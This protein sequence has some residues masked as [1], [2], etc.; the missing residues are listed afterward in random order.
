MALQKLREL[1]ETREIRELRET[2]EIREWDWLA[3]ADYMT[4]LLLKRCLPMSHPADFEQARPIVV[5][6]MF[7]RLEA[8]LKLDN[9]P[10]DRA[11]WV[12]GW[13]LSEG[14]IPVAVNMNIVTNE[15]FGFI[16]E[17]K[18][19]EWPI[20]SVKI[21]RY[22]WASMLFGLNSYCQH[23]VRTICSKLIETLPGNHII[24]TKCNWTM[25][26]TEMYND[27][28]C[29]YC[30]SIESYPNSTLKLLQCVPLI[31]LNE[32]DESKLVKKLKKIKIH[33]S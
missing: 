30:E 10:K 16:H 32:T 7:E 11:F 3:M 13:I 1:R 12:N 28:I 20:V 2:R 18:W 25:P 31:T 27:C 8:H 19:T 4:P 33:N 5:C 26:E 9:I 6:R 23:K 14:F 21:M 29:T 17:K 15:R 24:C 22:Y